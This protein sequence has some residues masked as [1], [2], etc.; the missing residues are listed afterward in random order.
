MLSKLAIVADNQ[1]IMFGRGYQ[2][3]APLIVTPMCGAFET[4]Q[5]EAVK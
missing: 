2:I 3:K 1:R 4:A 5:E